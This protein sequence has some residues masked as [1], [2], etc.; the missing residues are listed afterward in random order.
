MRCIHWG[1]CV[2][3]LI[4]VVAGCGPGPVAVDAANL[5]PAGWSAQDTVRLFFE[6]EHPEHRHDLQFGFRHS[7]DYPFSNLYLFVKLQYPNGRTLTDTLECPLAA[8]TGEWY[9]E[10]GRWIDHR[11]GYKRGVAFPL[12]GAYSLEVV[13]AMRRDPLPGVAEMRFALFDR[14]AD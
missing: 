14:Q 11:I 7:S 4:L 5:D 6:V 10:G 13:H 3:G 8:A 12:A 1:T 2:A 9:G